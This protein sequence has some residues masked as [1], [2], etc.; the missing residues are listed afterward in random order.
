MIPFKTLN[1]LIKKHSL[2]EKELSSEEIDKN[3][4]AEKS[5]EYADLCEVIKIAKVYVSFEKNR[6]E[7]KTILEDKNSDPDLLKMAEAELEKLEVENGK[8]EKKIKVIFIT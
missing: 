8:N 3:S 4:F 7:I 2:L 6:K 5:K 1:D